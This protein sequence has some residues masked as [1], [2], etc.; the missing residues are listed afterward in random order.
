MR[1]FNR[2]HAA[3]WTLAAGLMV[4]AVLG[5]Q[6]HRDAVSLD[7]Q[8]LALRVSEIQGQLDARLEKS[9]MLLHN[10]RDYLLFS[11]ESH[12]AVFERWCYENGLSI[13]CP[14]LHGIVVATNRYVTR[15]RQQLPPDPE[16]WTTNDTARL[17]LLATRQ[18]ITCDI[19]LRSEVGNQKQFLTDY[20]LRPLFGK[21]YAGYSSGSN[22]WLAV[23]I[24]QS[25]RLG[26][27]RQRTVML[28][29]DGNAITGTLFYV[30]LHRRDTADLTSGE[31]L[32]RDVKS[33]VR[34]L[35]LESLIVAP[36]DFKA[37]VK[38]VWDDAPADLGVE[39]FSSPDQTAA[40][41]L[42]SSGETPRAADP[43]FKP[44]LSH[45]R[46]WQMYGI[47]F[48][49]YFYTTPLFEAQSPR[50]LAQTAVAAGFMVTLLAT[51]LVGVAGRARSRQDEMTAQIRE[52]RDA[53]AAAQREREKFSRDL[54]DGTIQS[55]YAIQLGLGH[56]V[57]K[58]EAAP[59]RARSEM[60]VVRKE[61]DMVI[62]EI[63]QFITA[64]AEVEQ[65]VDFCAV[66]Q[67]LVQRARPGARAQIEARCD[68]G[69]S[70]RLTVD[71]AVQLANIAREALSNSL[72]HAKPQRVEIGLRL[73]GESVLL[74]VSDDGT[75][76]DPLAPGGSGVGLASM[77]TRTREMAGTL[78][79]QSAPARGTRLTVRVPV[80]PL[81]ALET[82]G[83][84]GLD[85]ES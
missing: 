39:I 19:A 78:D 72:R 24:R 66:L 41:W 73:D 61:L 48:S 6:L 51:A 79:I 22:D 58:L 54:H 55:L 9:E 8:R 85:D 30:P 49:L 29:A 68:P 7:R 28:G 20:D 70:R 76:F 2:R 16:T 42:N 81:E 60:T 59:A 50:R 47:K 12:N 36:V 4:T 69:A 18:P 13:N 75:G 15:W 65:T 5:W 45:R 56:T 38:S 46:N 33:Y 84:D 23:T 27:S 11:G 43:H 44:Y 83:P 62:A 1:L 52:A 40:T 37:L 67:A 64:G 14:W 35:Q 53:L 82:E 25:S 71:Q 32:S 31:T 17:G 77:T 63:R 74:E 26:M 21:A 57:E 80:S 3:W 34:W 10:L